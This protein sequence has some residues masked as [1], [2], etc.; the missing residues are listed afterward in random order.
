MNLRH[1][2]V[3][4]GLLLSTGIAASAQTAAGPTSYTFD[5]SGNGGI[6]SLSNPFQI[7]RNPGSLVN[8]VL[9]YNLPS[10]ETPGD[11]YLNDSP[12]GAPAVIGEVLRFTGNGTVQFYSDNSD[13]VD[14]LADTSGLPAPILTNVVTVPEI[15]PEGSNG[16]IYTP[17]LG[18]PG[19]N[20]AA[21]VG[22]T[23]YFIV[24][25]SPVPEASSVVSL[26]LLLM[27]GMGGVVVTLR[28][29]SRA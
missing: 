23:S 25:D 17:T 27:L 7:A 9:T 19:Y 1:A 6:Q 3:A 20:P 21:G 10:A 15:G 16:A 26:G 29:R 2:L 14:S 12:V 4:S 28:K 22:G 8:R 13:G 18:Q 24:S 11:L 5:E